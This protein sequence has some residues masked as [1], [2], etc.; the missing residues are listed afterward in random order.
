MT[1]HVLGMPWLLGSFNYR[2]F[3]MDQ[4]YLEITHSS[5]ESQE[6]SNYNKIRKKNTAKIIAHSLLHTVT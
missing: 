4:G 6:K 1:K 5:V 3:Q 2:P